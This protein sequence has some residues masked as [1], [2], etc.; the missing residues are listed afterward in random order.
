MSHLLL[1]T[2]A[3][4]CAAK[5]EYVSVITAGA[6]VAGGLPRARVKIALRGGVNLGGAARVGTVALLAPL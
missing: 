5:L 4:P 2:K 3:G 6:C 1:A